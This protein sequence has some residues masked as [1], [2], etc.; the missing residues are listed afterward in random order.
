MKTNQNLLHYFIGLTFLLGVATGPAVGV[1]TPEP[2]SDQGDQFRHIEQ[3]ILRIGWTLGGFA[4][5]G[6]LISSAIESSQGESV[7]R[8]QGTSLDRHPMSSNATESASGTHCAPI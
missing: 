4:L 2:F 7:V 3:P 1:Q 8:N 5:I 6:I